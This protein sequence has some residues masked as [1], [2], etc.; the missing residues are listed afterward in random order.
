M[1]PGK[2]LLK[3]SGWGVVLV[4]S[5]LLYGLCPLAW[6]DPSAE[7]Q[8]R[9][10]EHYALDRPEGGGPFPAVMMVPGCSGFLGQVKGIYERAAKRLKDEGFVVLKVDYQAARGVPTCMSVNQEGVAQDIAM[11]MK[12]LRAQSFVKTSAINVIGWS[13]GGGASLVALANGDNSSPAPADAV[14]TYYPY[15]DSLAS[16]WKVDVPVLI[17]FG[18]EDS[19]ASSQAVERLLSQV[20][21]RDRVKFLVYPDARHCFDDSDLPALMNSMYGPL[22]YNE[23]AAKMAWE[24]VEQFLRR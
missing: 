4:I 18:A 10:E 5:A 16:P 12:Y 21:A 17:L 3:R 6:A 13:F 9:L 1:E 22:G 2:R 23:K 14:V 20:P 8:R 19:V 7:E 24:E 11:A 15:I